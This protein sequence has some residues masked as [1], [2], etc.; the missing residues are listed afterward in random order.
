MPYEAHR[1]AGVGDVLPKLQ[2]RDMY[3]K[4]AL[5]RDDMFTVA[6]SFYLKKDEKSTLPVV[7]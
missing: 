4:R 5:K 1:L 6:Y 3:D 7:F 2:R